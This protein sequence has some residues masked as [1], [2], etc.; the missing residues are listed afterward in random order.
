MAITLSYSCSCG[1]HS[2]ILD[3]AQKHANWEGHY[4]DVSGCMTPTVETPLKLKGDITAQARAKAKDAAIM[5]AARD[6]GLLKI[7]AAVCVT[8]TVAFSSSACGAPLSPKDAE[9]G[10][11]VRQEVYFREASTGKCLRFQQEALGNKWVLWKVV[12][13]SRCERKVR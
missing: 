12:E 3:D 11:V 4:V 5:R 9:V 13:T 6:R 1:F 10:Q 8:A 2:G 7:V